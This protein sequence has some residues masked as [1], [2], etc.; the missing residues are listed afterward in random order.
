[1]T[2]ADLVDELPAAKP[3]FFEPKGQTGAGAK[4]GG[5]TPPSGK[6]RSEMTVQGKSAY[7]A[8]NGP[9][10][11]LIPGLG[12]SSDRCPCRGHGSLRGRG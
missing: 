4:P 11:S 8:A 6:K 12:S 2:I 7:V 9:G 1:M 10:R 5:G 3:N